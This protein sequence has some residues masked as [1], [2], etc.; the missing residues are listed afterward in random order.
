MCQSWVVQ[1]QESI[2]LCKIPLQYGLQEIHMLDTCTSHVYFSVSVYSGKVK[3]FAMY[4]DNCKNSQ[5]VHE[6]E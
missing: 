4:L 2:H 6:A 1:N 5:Y 3:S